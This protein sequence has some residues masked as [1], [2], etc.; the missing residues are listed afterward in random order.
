MTKRSRIVIGVTVSSVIALAVVALAFLVIAMAF[1]PVDPFPRAQRTARCT[2]N[3]SVVLYERKTGWFTS[4]T[5]LSVR[6]IDPTGRVVRGEG[7][8]TF[9]R[10][11]DSEMNV[12]ETPE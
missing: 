5:E 1:E 10:W 9:P 12:L 3:S 6:F 2:N 11:N 4:E 7:L 8:G